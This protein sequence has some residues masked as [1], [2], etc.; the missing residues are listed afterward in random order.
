MRDDS[1]FITI[2]KKQG[3]ISIYVVC[4][5]QRPRVL[6]AK[7]HDVV[8]NEELFD[9]NH[10]LEKLHNV[11]LSLHS[12]KRVFEIYLFYKI[13]AMHLLRLSTQDT[14]MGEGD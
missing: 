1:L 3:N 14:S 6:R 8:M 7:V 11:F 2:G 4:L 10:I 13:C 12:Q 5:S 9:L